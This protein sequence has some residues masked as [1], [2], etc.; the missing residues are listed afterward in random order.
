MAGTKIS[1]LPAATTP[2]TGTELVP[3]VQGGVTVK[4]TAANINAAA[5]YT[6]T[7]TGAV[8]RL[9]SSKLGDFVSVKDFGAVGDGVTDDTAAIQAALDYQASATSSFQNNTGQY[10]GTGPVLF[11]P[12]GRYLI[13]STLDIKTEYSWLLGEQAS[14]RKSGGFT[15]TAG[16]QMAGGAWRIHVESLQ[17]EDFDVGLY[18][19]SSNL[20]SGQIGIHNCG[21]FGCTDRAIWLDAQSTK[22][23]IKDCMFRS[24]KHDLWIETGDHVVVSGGWINRASNLLTD[25]YDGYIVNYGRL[26]LRDVL[27]VPPSSETVSEWAWV[28]NY[29][30]VDCDGF[31]FGGESGG[32]PAVNNFAWGS[33]WGTQDNKSSVLVRNCP[34]YGGSS[35]PAVRLFYPPNLI[36]LE[37]NTGLTGSG[38]YAI[39]WSSSVSAPDQALRLPTIGSSQSRW[40]FIHN[41]NN[42]GQDSIVDA[43]LLQF[44]TTNRQLRL[45]SSDSDAQN[46]IFDY[47]QAT[48]LAGDIYGTVEWNGYDASNPS[49]VGRRGAI[50]GRSTSTNG[51]LELVFQTGIAGGAVTDRVVIEAGGAVRPAADATQQ[52]GTASYRWSQVFAV[53]PA[54]NTS[55]ARE[56]QQVRSVSDAENRV[57][58]R[59]KAL[60]KAFKFNS[61]VE[62]KGDA[63]RIHF[64]VMAQELADA[65][66]AEGLNPEHYAMFCYDKWDDVYHDVT[67]TKTI[68]NE[69][70]TSEEVRVPTGEKVLVQAA[71][72]RYGIRYEELLAFIIAV[73]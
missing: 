2:L 61:A 65:F 71:G 64:G 41:R 8:S 1:N 12:E 29:G 32:V 58:Q 47:L 69:D 46:L 4:A 55:D 11:F 72:D 6:S 60:L 42:N 35:R 57:A 10:I 7:G 62:Q 59:A 50:I 40:F 13:S 28:A 37:N 73:L 14:L 30:A 44:A 38:A 48:I 45:F 25:N 43:N 17:F 26:T 23:I 22:T 27:A 51:G 49:N 56:K 9:I 21:F 3:V 63:A 20:N 54:I 52:L 15:G 53:A 33:P 39:G 24:N 68:V 70:G 18:L 66:V 67:E 31:R 34:L 36:V 19:D 5:T 16:L